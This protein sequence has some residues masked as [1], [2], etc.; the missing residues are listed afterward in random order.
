MKKFLSYLIVIIITYFIS[1]Y[2]NNS[3]FRQKI[4][5]ILQPKTK[6]IIVKIMYVK[7]KIAYVK[8]EPKKDAQILGTLRRNVEVGLIEIQNEWAKIKT[9]AGVVGWITYDSLKEEKPKEVVQNK[10]QKPKEE[11]QQESQETQYEDLSAGGKIPSSVISA[12][13][14][15][16]SQQPQEDIPDVIQQELKRKQTEIQTQQTTAKQ[17]T[18]FTKQTST[19][20]VTQELKQE[21]QPTQEA[22]T[23]TAPKQLKKEKKKIEQPPTTQEETIICP[24]CGAE[25][26]KGERFCPYCREPLPLQ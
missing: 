13:D 25:V 23:T 18:T 10:P 4:I 8:T 16:T 9:P 17:Q 3:S 2:I 19:K 24:N 20:Q 12:F 26:I 5:D 21:Q 6:D 22:T 15:A 7:P 1:A 11:A 14:N